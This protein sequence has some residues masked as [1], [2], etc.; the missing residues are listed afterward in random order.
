MSVKSQQNQGGQT[1]HENA[2]YMPS[3]TSEVILEESK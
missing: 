1:R 3:S 2:G